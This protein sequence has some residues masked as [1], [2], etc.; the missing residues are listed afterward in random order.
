MEISTPERAAFI[1]SA[2][3]I[4]SVQGT[5]TDAQNA[6]VSII[7]NGQEQLGS[8]GGLSVPFAADLTTPWGLTIITA[9]ATDACGNQSEV[10]QAFIRSDAFYAAAT[11]VDP[12]AKITQGL[13][14]HF[15]QPAID[16][17]V[18]A[19]FDDMASIGQAVS[20]SVD[21]AASLNAGVPNVLA[22]DTS[23]AG[24]SCSGIFDFWTELYYVVTR[25]GIAVG[26]PTI[27]LIQAQPQS[28]NT[29]VSVSNFGVPINA[30]LR[31]YTCTA[32]VK[33]LAVNTNVGGDVTVQDFSATADLDVDSVAGEIDVGV[34]NL[35][36][37]A[38]IDI[39]LSCGFPF[40]TLCNAIIEPIINLFINN[41][42]IQSFA[43]LFLQFIDIHVASF[44]VEYAPGDTITL[45]PPFN[46]SFGI[47]LSVDAAT[48]AGPAGTGSVTLEYGYQVIPGARG[49]TIPVTAPG[50]PRHDGAAI[51]FANQ[52]YELGFGIKDDV[53]NQ[54]LWAVWYQGVLED[55]DLTAL[56]ATANL[57]VE[58]LA[59]R[60]LLPPV[61]MPDG[62]PNRIQVGLGDVLID[63]S[64]D[65]DTVLGPPFTGVVSFE[66]VGSIVFAGTLN[67]D[68][69]SQSL[70]F[71]LD[72]TTVEIQIIAT[73]AP[74][75]SI[76]ALQDFVEQSFENIS[77]ALVE[78]LLRRVTIPTLNLNAIAPSVFA[79]GEILALAGA[80]LDR[81][82]DI[83]SRITGFT[84]TE[85][86]TDGDGT[87]DFGDNCT[88]V[89]NASQLDTDSDGIG[90]ACDADLDNNCAIN[91]L[92]LGILKSVFFT[93]A[94]DADFNGDGAVNF[95]DLGIMKA[96]FFQQPGPSS[97]LN[98]CDPP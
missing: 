63:A 40:A 47:G 5:A 8:P 44:L 15:N 83:A 88:L 42:L 4:V 12:A 54:L 37:T 72:T 76:A 2:S 80:Q 11:T 96:S 55:L 14:T 60:P 18:R 33:L 3:D 50:A 62:Q 16:D 57:P 36:A 51:T 66:A 90:N 1:E 95:L 7:V 78:R 48:V 41:N 59:L 31:Q 43:N 56:I 87:L 21:W 34:S 84:A 19:T 52:G 39:D 24:R 70:G 73:D 30:N 22:A 79:E 92:D 13:I 35:T 27:D 98:I 93:T 71:D 69:A 46:G 91:F 77:G 85:T 38:N 17:Q 97:L 74:P 49:T 81:P 68:P 58:N 67:L 45:P 9:S 75:V 23:A 65:L 32:G 29:G 28:L 25:G 94:P 10:A 64:I 82:G 61:L 6:I 53:V 86:D 89:A 26:S 20:D